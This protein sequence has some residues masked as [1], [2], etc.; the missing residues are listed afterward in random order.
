MQLK[1][2]HNNA[3]ICPQICTLII[4][5]ILIHINNWKKKLSLVVHWVPVHVH[6]RTEETVLSREKKSLSAMDSRIQLDTVEYRT[7]YG[8]YNFI[9]ATTKQAVF[10][11]ARNEQKRSLIEPYRARN[12]SYPSQ[13]VPYYAI[14]VAMLSQL[15]TGCN[16]TDSKPLKGQEE[17]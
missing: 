14:S 6:W 10:W 1:R 2:T 4:C 8:I 15:R 5:K 7:L 17:Y 13:S 9:N 12:V 16:T 11:H 3:R